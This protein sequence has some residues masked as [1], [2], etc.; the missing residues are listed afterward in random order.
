MLYYRFI[1]TFINMK[2]KIQHDE[3]GRP[4]VQHHNEYDEN[5]N[6]ISVGGRFMVNRNTEYKY[7]IKN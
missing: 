6:L 7:R 1:N 3:Y 2:E 4:Y 5:G